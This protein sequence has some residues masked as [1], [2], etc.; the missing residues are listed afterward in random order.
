MNHL[1]LRN[2]ELRIQIKLKIM[3][4]KVGELGPIARNMGS[5]CLHKAGDPGVRA[6]VIHS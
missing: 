4:P 1:K 2:Y 6:F 3:G 5:R